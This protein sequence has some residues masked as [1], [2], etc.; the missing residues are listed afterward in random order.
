MSTQISDYDKLFPFHFKYL[1]SENKSLCLH[2][3]KKYD[4]KVIHNLKR[5]IIEAH[6]I[7][8]ESSDLKYNHRKRPAPSDDTN[9]QPTSKIRKLSPEEFI[10]SCVELATIHLIPYNFFSFKSFKKLIDEN[11]KRHGLTMNSRNVQRYVQMTAGEIKKIIKQEVQSCMIAIKVDI[12]SRFGRSIL[13]VNAQFFSKMENK[14]VTRT[15]GM[16]EMKKRHTAQNINLMISSLLDEYGIDKRNISG[17]VCDNGANIIAAAKNFMNQQNSLLLNDEIAEM[18]AEGEYDEDDEDDQEN[19]DSNGPI[20]IPNNIKEALNDI[21]SIAVLVRCSIHTLQL[22]V[23]DSLK[24]ISKNNEYVLNNVRKVVKNLRSSAFV[25][26]INSLGIKIPG[27]DVLTRWNSS[28]IIIDK[29]MKIKN[30]LN[31]LYE[32]VT[33]NELKSIQLYDR[34]WEFMEKFHRAFHPCY[35]LT[36]KLQK[37]DSGMGKIIEI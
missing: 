27:N 18:V 36:M 28:Y 1:E 26:H 20:D 21:T 12:A 34:D 37:S 10:I 3:N 19:F 13:G 32:R 24:E 25:E 31:L 2:C 29:L 22:A 30:D 17:Y 6:P 11:E 4:K 23:H 7:Y 16:I 35:E 9:D 15:L 5:H 8:A 14:V 33:E